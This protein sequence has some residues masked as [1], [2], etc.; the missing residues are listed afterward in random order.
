MKE[1]KEAISRIEKETKSL[2]G[3]ISNKYWIIQGLNKAV[4]ICQNVQDESNNSQDLLKLNN[5]FGLLKKFKIYYDKVDGN[6]KMS[7][8]HDERIVRDF[9]T[10]EINKLNKL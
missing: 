9:I 2:D 6:I 10:D 3:S 4:E 8:S 1:L 5:S 7:D